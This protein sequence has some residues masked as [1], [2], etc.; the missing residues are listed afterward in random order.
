MKYQNFTLDPFQRKAVAAVDAG[1]DVIVSAPTGSGKTL[2][3]EYALEKCLQ[4]G[5][6]AVYTAPVKAL[7]NQKF[8]GFSE[9][10]PGRVG[11]MT[12]DVVIN[13]QAGLLIMTTE[14]FRNSR[15]ENPDAYRDLGVLVLDEIHFLADEQRGTVWEESIMLAPGTA[16]VLGLS[17]TV[18]NIDELASWMKSIR[19]TEIEVIKSSSRPVPLE[20]VCHV[21]NAGVMNL[22]KYYR[23]K[24]PGHS[25]QDPRRHGL[26]TVRRRIPDTGPLIVYM[27]EHGLLPCLYFLPSRRDCESRAQKACGLL[28]GPDIDDNIMQRYDAH[29]NERG[30]S[31][32]A[33]TVDLRGMIRRRVAYHHAGLLPA[34]KEIVEVLF[35]QGHI[36]IL[37][38]TETF[39][40]GVNMPARSAVFET[41]RKFDGIRVRPMMVREFQQMS[42][43]A[44]R[45]GMDDIGTVFVAR[46]PVTDDPGELRRLLESDPE[47]VS[48]R[49]NLSYSGILNLYTRYGS[50]LRPFLA[51]SFAAWQNSR[52]VRSLEKQFGDSDI[53]NRPQCPENDP[54]LIRRYQRVAN[55]IGSVSGQIGR[56]GASNRHGNSKR[57]S[58]LKK[59]LEN[60]KVM[61]S[62]MPCRKCPEYVRCVGYGKKERGIKKL[63]KQLDMQKTL[64]ERRFA[65]EVDLRIDFLRS[66]G[67]IGEKELSPQGMLASRVFGSEIQVAQCMCDGLFD[68]LSPVDVCALAGAILAEDP[69]RFLRGSKEKQVRNPLVVSALRRIDWLVK[70]ERSFGI[71]SLLT[72]AHTHLVEATRAWASGCRFEELSDVCDEADGDLVRHF[73]QIL[74]LLRNAAHAVS[75]TSMRNRLYACM[76]LINRDP[77]DPRA[78]LGLGTGELEDEVL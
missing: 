23:Y 56:M 3:A 73:R 77:V 12:G 66:L 16:S 32:L 72:G 43:R 21:E 47:P 42:G 25:G 65:D 52:K 14:V 13:P 46:D 69:P 59:R 41:I 58:R 67:Y 4:A 63:G 19:G 17:A 9:L 39:A 20:V 61:Q 37:H 33:A 51:R 49:L 78:E 50:D 6:R 35:S 7:S 64:L 29:C 57:M 40:L 54:G 22:E 44:G 75:E 28:R 15:M 1:K 70:A 30:I 18:P 45:R 53:D 36:A 26:R 76:K 74:D 34:L 68:L 8:R 38:T 71:S 48:S 5:K 27:E 62:A 24:V 55:R 11:I 31:H 10:Y 2:I 60:F